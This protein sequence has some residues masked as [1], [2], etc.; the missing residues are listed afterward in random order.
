MLISAQSPFPGSREDSG[1]IWKLVG[2]D[3]LTPPPTRAV[4]GVVGKGRGRMG[5]D[6]FSTDSLAS[7]TTIQ[8]PPP[9]AHEFT[10]TFSACQDCA[11]PG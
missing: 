2:R 10:G 5:G 11:T 7:F 6:G 3:C 9:D 8:L 1:G 4:G